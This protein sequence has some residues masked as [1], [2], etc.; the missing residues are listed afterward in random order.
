M[1][2]IKVFKKISVKN[3]IKKAAFSWKVPAFA[4]VVA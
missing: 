3:T 1:S 4:P 2:T